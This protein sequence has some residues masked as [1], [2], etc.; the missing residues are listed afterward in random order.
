MVIIPGAFIERSNN[1]NGDDLQISS[2][3][4][5]KDG[6]IAAVNSKFIHLAH[7]AKL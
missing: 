3:V 2:P 1:N 6:M 4:I 5:A 7:S